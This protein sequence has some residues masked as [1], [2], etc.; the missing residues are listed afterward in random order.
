MGRCIL[1]SGDYIRFHRNEFEV[2]IGSMKGLRQQWS[3]RI[4]T[5]A[6][7]AKKGFPGK[8]WPGQT[9]WHTI[10]LPRDNLVGDLDCGTKA[11]ARAKEFRTRDWV[12]APGRRMGSITGAVC[13]IGT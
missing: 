9:P 13:Q 2:R 6:S 3:F 4:A 5:P 8:E 11:Y 10:G 7:R 12:R 1:V